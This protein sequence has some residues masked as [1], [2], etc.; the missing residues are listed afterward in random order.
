MLVDIKPIYDRQKKKRLPD[1]KRP[2][3][4]KHY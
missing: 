1:C 2:S 4:K 3:A